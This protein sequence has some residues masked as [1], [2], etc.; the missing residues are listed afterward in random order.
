MAADSA[1]AGLTAR[2]LAGTDYLVAVTTLLQAHRR[3][4]ATRGL[5]EAADLQWW[6]TRD[7]H[8][9]AGRARVWY[10]GTDPILAAVLTVWSERHAALDV[11]GDVSRPEPWEWLAMSAPA[12]A[13]AHGWLES[14]APEGDEGWQESLAALGFT[15]ADETYL[16]MWRGAADVPD[17]PAAP[18]GYRVTTR[19]E[20]T[21]G[22]HWL[23]NRNGEPVETRLRQCSLYDPGCDIAVVHEASD[24]VVAYSLYWPDPITGVGLVEPVRVE[25]KHSGRG[26]GGV[27]LRHGLAALR[28]TG[29]ARLK[30]SA[31]ETNT[32]AVRLYQG[33]GFEVG[34]RERTWRL[35]VADSAT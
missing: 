26:I 30:V 5:W 14:A 25:D 29:C 23:A 15:A 9:E 28:D 22:S 32:A 6:W 4:H 16:S 19:R 34:R 27:M 35:T 11:L 12:V 3:T 33:A 20:R 2:D 13:M 21:R 24:Q 7:P 17:P 8:D 10:D 18:P 31:V 1:S